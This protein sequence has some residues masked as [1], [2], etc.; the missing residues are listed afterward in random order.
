MKQNCY[1]MPKYVAGLKPQSILEIGCGNGRVY[2]QL[3]SYEY[4]AQ[5]TGLD[6]ADYLI[7]EN[8]ERHPEAT[9]RQGMVYELPFPDA[10][11]HQRQSVRG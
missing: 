9:W 3:R 4:T 8:A 2:R 6:V 5:Y 10:S 11:D 7:Q 1:L